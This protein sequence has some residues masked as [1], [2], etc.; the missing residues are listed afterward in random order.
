[1][2]PGLVWRKRNQTEAGPLECGQVLT[3]THEPPVPATTQKAPTTSVDLSPVELLTTLVLLELENGIVCPK[4]IGVEPVGSQPPQT[5]PT[6]VNGASPTTAMEEL[7]VGASGHSNVATLS[8][9]DASEAFA[10]LEEEK[11]A[12]T[13]PLAELKEEG[14]VV[15]QGESKKGVSAEACGKEKGEV[16]GEG[17]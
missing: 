2:K 9:C 11:M 13:L 17:T 15:V 3:D 12:Q 10:K 4:S 1:M 7:D 8:W 5:E 6:A 14:R 16:E